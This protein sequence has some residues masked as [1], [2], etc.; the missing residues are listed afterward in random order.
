MA[1]VCA[2]AAASGWLLLPEHA[3]GKMPLISMVS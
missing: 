1:I 2:G 3:V